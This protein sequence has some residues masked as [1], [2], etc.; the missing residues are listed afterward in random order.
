MARRESGRD[1]DDLARERFG[2]FVLAVAAIEVAERQVVPIVAG[3]RLDRLLVRGDDGVGV[4]A[5]VCER[6]TTPRLGI[7]RLELGDA[8]EVA[9]RFLVP[10]VLLGER[11]GREQH[12]GRSGVQAL[13]G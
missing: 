5:L 7:R 13:R 2:S 11:A 8:A 1:L 6:E 3:L 9:D 12:R 4:R 10:A